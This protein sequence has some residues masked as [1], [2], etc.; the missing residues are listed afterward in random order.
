M[1]IYK[2]ILTMPVVFIN[3]IQLNETAE[4]KL[5]PLLAD[6]V[7]VSKCFIKICINRY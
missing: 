4:E 5:E 7:G 2:L 6:K 3:G 1:K